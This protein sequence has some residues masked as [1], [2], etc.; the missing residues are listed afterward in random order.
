MQE[1]LL[2]L[3]KIGKVTRGSGE[4]VPAG[5]GEGRGPH[6]GLLANRLTIFLFVFHIDSFPFARL[7]AKQRRR[8]LRESC[9]RGK[10]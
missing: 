7:L 9:S 5:A 4:D 2:K 3:H 8:H 1:L 6:E 10:K